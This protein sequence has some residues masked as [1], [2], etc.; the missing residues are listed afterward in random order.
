MSPITQADIVAEARRW[1]GTPYHHQASIRDIGTD[2]IGLVLG[3]LRAVN[4]AVP[5]KLPGYSRDWAEASGAETLLAAAHQHLIE[6]S[7][8]TAEAGDILIFRYRP[9]MVAKHAGIVA[10]SATFIH[11]LEGAPV[12]E[13]AL[14]A[15]WRRRIAG[16]FRIPGIID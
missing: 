15:W 9:R 10:T 7:P 13:V 1:I 16:A 11:A 5:D 12:S 4:I 6:V 2:C 14:N 3:V 8:H